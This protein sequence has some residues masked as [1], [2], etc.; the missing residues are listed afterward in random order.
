[1]GEGQQP[2]NGSSDAVLAF[3]GGVGAQPTILCPGAARQQTFIHYKHAVDVSS[4]RTT[5]ASQ[6]RIHN[7][8]PT[9][10]LHVHSGVALPDNGVEEQSN[11]HAQKLAGASS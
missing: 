10:R 1:M 3:G 7:P 9:V 4:Q 2:F 8:S 11:Q 5:L 6:K